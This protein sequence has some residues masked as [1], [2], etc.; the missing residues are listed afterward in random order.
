LIRVATI[1]DGD[2]LGVRSPQGVEGPKVK[3][4]CPRAFRYDNAGLLEKYEVAWSE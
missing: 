3:T 1:S 4:P 2:A